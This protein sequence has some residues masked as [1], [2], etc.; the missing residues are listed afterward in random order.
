VPEGQALSW[1]V[2]PPSKDKVMTEST[3]VYTYTD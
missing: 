2:V 3:I 1:S